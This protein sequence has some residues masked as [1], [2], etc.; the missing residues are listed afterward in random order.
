MVNNGSSSPNT[1]NTVE[2]NEDTGQMKHQ[3]IMMDIK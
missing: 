1:G 3:K 2:V